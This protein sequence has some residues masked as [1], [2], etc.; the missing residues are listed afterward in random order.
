LTTSVTGRPVTQ[1]TD[2]QIQAPTGGA[3]TSAKTTPAVTTSSKA[4][5]SSS[6]TTVRPSVARY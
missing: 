6:S 3:T 5:S 2:G 1:I 4:S